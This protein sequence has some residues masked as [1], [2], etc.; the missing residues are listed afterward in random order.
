M[1]CPAGEHVNTE[2]EKNFLQAAFPPSQT[3]SARVYTWRDGGQR[4]GGKRNGRRGMKM[5]TAEK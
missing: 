2:G 5:K 3:L 1:C 4:G